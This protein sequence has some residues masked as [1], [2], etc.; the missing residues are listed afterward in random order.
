ML[1]GRVVRKWILRRAAEILG[2]PGK[3]LER[4][5]KAAQYSSGIQRRLRKLLAEKKL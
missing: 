1:D 2:V 3:V 5:K 4:P